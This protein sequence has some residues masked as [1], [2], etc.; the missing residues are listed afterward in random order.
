LDIIKCRQ[1]KSIPSF[2]AKHA[3]HRIWEAM[4]SVRLSPGLASFVAQTAIDL[5]NSNLS[6]LP[7]SLRYQPLAQ[8]ANSIHGGVIQRPR[9]GSS[10]ARL[11]KPLTY[12]AVVLLLLV[13]VAVYTQYSNGASGT[14]STAGSKL[15][16][17]GISKQDYVDAV[18]RAPIEGVFDPD[19]IRRT[20][21]STKFQEGLVWHCVA[22]V[23]GI[24]NVGNEV[25]NCARYAIEAGGK[26]QCLAARL[27]AE[28]TKS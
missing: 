16:R 22:V 21:E 9:K 25:L 7:A 19:P 4:V 18:L 8:D 2:R 24:G 11:K 17:A 27:R 14:S 5:Y 12:A 1:I 13:A 23:G 20:C 3:K 15:I 6:R 28:G 10:L 26:A